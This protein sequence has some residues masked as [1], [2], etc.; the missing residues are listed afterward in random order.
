MPFIPLFVFGEIKKSSKLDGI[1]FG[2]DW[3]FLV[4]EVNMEMMIN[5]C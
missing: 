1:N 4:I 5:I 3:Q 2:Q